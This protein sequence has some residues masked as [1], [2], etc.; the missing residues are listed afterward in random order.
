[1]SCASLHIMPLFPD[2]SLITNFSVYLCNSYNVDSYKAATLVFF[3]NI[4]EIESQYT[5]STKFIQY[6]SY[7]NPW[8]T[9][10]LLNRFLNLFTRR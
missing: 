1:M 10:E 8:Q 2:R 3:L 9:A 6:A 4:E 7:T 5:D